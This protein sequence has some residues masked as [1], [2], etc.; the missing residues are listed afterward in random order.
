[1]FLEV[2][3]N[4]PKKLHKLH[5]DFPL[6]PERY[7]ITYNELS[8]INQFLYK[9]MQKNT[10]QD[11]YCEEKLIPTFH[12][13][14]YYILH[15]KCLLFYLSQGLIL[16]KIHRIVSFK[17][18]PFLKDYILT[19]TN[20][21]SISAA[22]NLTFFVNVFKLLANSTYGKFAQ[23]PK[24][25]TYAKLCLCER[26]LKKAI[27][28]SRFLRATIVNQNVSIV[29]YKPEKI[30]FDSPFPVAS[31]ILDLAKLHMYYYYY[32]VLKPTFAP[33]KVSLIM[34][35]TDSLV[36]SVNCHNFFGKYKKLNLFDFSN[37]KTNNF[38]Y[39][40]ENRKALLFFKDENPSDFIKEFIG[41]RSKLYVI[42]TVSN[43]EDKK[44]KGY[45][46]KFK[47]TLLTYTKYENCHKN[48][49]QLRLPL[50]SIR[51]FD[52]ELYTVLQNRVVLNNYDSKMFV[53]DCNIHTFFYY[54]NDI[55]AA[56]IKM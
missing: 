14:K 56:C 25:F 39:S 18:K 53:C 27:N 31:T 43:Y 2:D 17:Q 19:L 10:S 8:P 9:K 54:S 52:H 48:L 38:L 21:R 22:K 46:R 50:L 33:D 40:N 26:D 24:N 28:S 12:N 45:K 4:Y 34:T 32:D 42:K 20:L 51:S 55:N 49:T 1:M 30:L 23:N 13:R 6:A 37:F 44:C 7:K 36:F 16:K 11:T 5:E 3:L 15:I 47:D 29:E 41:L 35:D